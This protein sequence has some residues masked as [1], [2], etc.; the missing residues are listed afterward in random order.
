MKHFCKH[1]SFV[2]L[3]LGV[4]SSCQEKEPVLQAL[5]IPANFEV[6][7]DVETGQTGNVTITPSA[8]GALYFH[9]YF[10]TVPGADPIVAQAGQSASY[11]F[12]KSGQYTAPIFVIAY[13]Q[14]GV[15]SSKTI[16][17]DLDVRLKIDAATLQ[18]IAGNGSKR[19][20]W[21]S[22]E[23]GYFGVGPTSNDFPEFFSAPAGELNSCMNDD[24]L[25]FGYDANDN[26]TFDLETAA[27]NESFVNWAEVTQ[28]FPD[29][30]PGEF[31]D[32][33][34]DI[35]AQI[36]TSTSFIILDEANGKRTLDVEN[37]TLSYWSGAEE[38]EI[39]ELTENKLSVRGIQLVPAGGELA[40]YHTFVPEG[41]GN[42]PSGSAF[43][44][45]IWSEEFDADGAPNTANWNYDIGTGSNGWGNGESQYYTDRPENI[46]VEGGFLK[47]T[48]KAEVFNGSNY[49]SSRIHSDNKFQ[50]QYGRAEIRAKLPTGG[51]TWPALWTL[52]SNF[53]TV[54]WPECGEMDI[55][56]HVGNQ[57][58]TVSSATHDPNNF[59]G[60]A[61]AGSSNVPGVSDEFH[62]Y[63]MEWTATEIQFLID[64]ELYHTVSNDGSLPYN[65]DF[66]FILNVAMG[67][68]FG[69]AIDGAFAQSTMEVDYIR[70]YQ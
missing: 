34:R 58:D 29:A 42:T 53:D 27:N 22:T 25:V 19:W 51:G 36:A 40:W 50:F 26:Y 66:F 62:L 13:G 55:M 10:T 70:V 44:T 6:I 67:G 60:N 33:C 14:G 57:Q 1:F 2:F 9:I 46:I 28:F 64:N 68:S 69:G 59:A 24:V 54:G 65:Q 15:S 35:T 56:E 43:N 7:A 52:G 21:N 4:L 20:V 38:Y 45:L 30:T 16:M 61:R 39:V 11:R 32:E 17:V 5:S 3:L 31:V 23:A 37:S 48:A 47:I 12:T 49:T 41:G 63:S 18:L 8:D